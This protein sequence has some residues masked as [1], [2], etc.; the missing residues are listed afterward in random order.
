MKYLQKTIV[1]L[2][3]T[4]LSALHSVFAGPT[5]VAGDSFVLVATNGSGIQLFGLTQDA[6]G[7]I[8]A[9]NNPSG[10][11]IPLQ[12]F[13][14]FTF[15]NSP[16]QFENFGPVCDD[17]DGLAFAQ[18]YLYAASL[19]G[20]RQISVTNGNG[21]LFLP[22][23]AAN[24]TGSPLIV[25]VSDGHFFVGLGYNNGT[26]IREYDASGV[27]VKNHVTTLE[28]ETMTF[29]QTSGLIYYAPFG[30]AVHS[31][32]PSNDVDTLIATINGTID[33][34]LAFDY[35]SRR[36][37]VGTANGSNQG[38]VYTI[39]LSSDA[40]AIFASG[41]EGSLGVTREPLTGDLY[42]LENKN[43]YRINSTNVVNS[44]TP[45]LNIWTAVEL[46][47][48]SDTNQTYQIQWRTA[49]NTNT[50]FN[51]GSPIQGD[52]TTNFIFDTT[53]TNTQRF[54]RLIIVQ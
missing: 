16:V 25:R 33:G 44:L 32:N 30:S 3:V 20:I 1:F 15:S 6:Q 36:I 26:G 50:W 39:D 48:V 14:P 54:Y 7:N 21:T 47:W 5:S 9:G 42:F 11:G 10:P 38:S 19:Q 37:F 53:R 41:F 34:A 4:G 27:F 49:L 35:I 40:V 31:F 29:D 23:V 46:G 52:G 8:Y 18:G 2:A 45:T 17:A 28:V 51:L 12:K 24:L 13:R 43:L 22:S